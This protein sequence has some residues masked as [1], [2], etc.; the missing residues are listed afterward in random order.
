MNCFT[1]EKYGINVLNNLLNRKLIF[2]LIPCGRKG[3]SQFQWVN[4]IEL[5]PH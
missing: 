2:E 4:K 3:D 5:F 1:R